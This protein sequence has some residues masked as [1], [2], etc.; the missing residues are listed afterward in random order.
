[1]DC[2]S[3]KRRYDTLADADAQLAAIRDNDGENR[4]ELRA[5]LCDFCCGWHLTSRKPDDPLAR[6]RRRT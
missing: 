1:M 5:Y 3:R 2:S 6:R 4:H